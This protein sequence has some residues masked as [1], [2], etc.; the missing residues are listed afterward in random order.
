MAAW[1]APPS[2]PGRPAHLHREPA[3]AGRRVWRISQCPRPGRPTCPVIGAARATR[4]RHRRAGG[5]WMNGGGEPSS[6]NPGAP[7]GQ[8]SQRVV[9]DARGREREDASTCK[10]APEPNP[11]ARKQV[12]QP[13]T[14]MSRAGASCWPQNDRFGRHTTGGPRCRPERQNGGYA[15]ARA[16]RALV[17][18]CHPALGPIPH[19]SPTRHGWRSPGESHRRITDAPVLS[20]LCRER[21]ALGLLSLRSPKPGR[22][23]I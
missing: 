14:A 7:D 17:T 1:P 6:P 10:R 20:V 2:R 4:R 9:R 16:N 15:R 8:T 22:L 23:L 13:T 11:A 3:L 5:P 12:D 21:I 19:K 18:E